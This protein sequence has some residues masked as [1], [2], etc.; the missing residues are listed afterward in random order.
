MSCSRSFPLLE[1]QLTPE[2]LSEALASSDE[3]P[4]KASRSSS[5]DDEFRSY[6]ESKRRTSAPGRIRRSRRETD[7]AKKEKNRVAAKR[8]RLA[9]KQ[10]EEEIKERL[11]ELDARNKYLKDLVAQASL[12]V[13]R[14]KSLMGN[15]YRV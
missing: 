15:V 12:E 6:S 11:R 14:I 9:R 4:K 3:D 7:D 1:V 8:H 2:E 10:R 5:Y 13:K